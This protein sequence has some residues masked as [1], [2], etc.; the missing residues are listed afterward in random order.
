VSI[1]WLRGAVE[2]LRAVHAHI[3]VENPDAA[4]RVVQAIR[5]TTTRLR[6]FPTSGR[7]GTVAGT[8]EIVVPN[9]PIIVVYRTVGADV[10]ILRVFHTAVDWQAGFQ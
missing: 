8:R 5:S 1:R 9:L 2:S 4:R 10:E 3:A 7:N 6:E